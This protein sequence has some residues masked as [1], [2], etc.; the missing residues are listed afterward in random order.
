MWIQAPK[1]RPELA[2]KLLTKQILYKILLNYY[3][4]NTNI[5]WG[6]KYKGEI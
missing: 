1:L 4:K 2:I 5:R 3:Y 6:H